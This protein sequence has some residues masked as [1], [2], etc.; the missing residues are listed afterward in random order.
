MGITIVL[1]SQW[2]DEGKGKITDMLSQEATLC[3]RAAGGHNA[4]HTIV[5]DNITYDFHILPSGLVSPKCVNLIG[6]GTV[7]HVPSFFKELASLEGKGLKGAGKRIFISDRAHVCFDLHSVVDGLE[8]ARLG[9]RKVGTTGKGIG[10]C[11]SDK[12]ARRGVRVGEIMDEAVFE[13]KL[14]TLHAG[15]TARFGDLEY[16]VE[17]EIG[18]F[19]EYRQRLVPYIVDQL[20]FFKQYKD[21]PNTLVE[22][23]NALMLDLD[24]GTYPYVTSSST[25]LGGAVQALSLNPASI[26][27]IIG[28]VKAYT[29][30]VG[31]GPFPSEQ[32]NEYGDKLQSVGRE[33]G[34]TTGRR[35]RCGWFD[36]VLCRYSHAINHY[37]ALNLTKLDVLDD[38]DEIKVGVAY[39]LPD[40][41]RLTD[42]YPAD[43]AVQENVKVEY[44]TLPG[45][46]S[47]TMGVQKYED[48]PANARAYIEY[49]ER[50]LGGV[51]VKWIGT[52]P[53]RDHMICRE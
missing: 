19:K 33:F 42:T 27:S 46:K 10:P 23:A 14:R 4:G 41:T 50:E 13:R 40:G 36:L 22:G 21:S 8:E 5:H 20:A 9:G 53:A 37:T 18:R 16:D 6:A 35:R 48:L 52:G 1:G 34:V 51:P 2:G 31:S 38:F 15:Y 11:Y 24:H 3:C 17:E 30:R 25:G 26:T 12:A 32:L 29:T 28:V 45:W 44:V 7:V 47:N 49:I 43:A 39:V